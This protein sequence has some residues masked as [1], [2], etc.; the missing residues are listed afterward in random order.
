[1]IGIKPFFYENQERKR[2]AHLALSKE[3]ANLFIATLTAHQVDAV[4]FGSLAMSSEAVDIDD[5]SFF[6]ENSDIDICILSN[7]GADM[8][9]F[10]IELLARRFF[11][12]FGLSF[13]VWRKEDL[14]SSVMEDVNKFGVKSVL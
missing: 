8:S 9:F 14:N 11:K 2:L 7:G 3:K 12:E 1:M 10:D 13:D 6:R 4:I 5:Q